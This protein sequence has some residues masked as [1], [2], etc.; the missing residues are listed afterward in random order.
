MREPQT[1]EA[2]AAV[3]CELYRILG[4]SHIVESKRGKE[5]S[6]PD[7]R[8]EGPTPACADLCLDEASL[9]PVR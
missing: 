5:E 4:R 2:Y 6:M 8:V 7:K 3:M 9:H 1:G